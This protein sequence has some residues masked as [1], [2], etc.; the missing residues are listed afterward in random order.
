MENENLY[1]Q[2][3]VNKYRAAL[4]DLFRYISWFEQ[5][6]GQKSF[7]MYT[8]DNSPSQSVPIPVY[9]STLLSFVKEMQATGLMDRNY[10]Y[11][12]T[13]N[14]IGNMEDELAAIEHAGLKE[15]DVVMGILSKYV[16]GGMTKGVL[17][18]QAVDGGIFLH[19]LLKMKDLLDIWDKPLA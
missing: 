11:I 2:E 15:I 13:R 14:R 17:W 16:L 8:G 19:A 6:Q 5:K 9:D 3:M 18:T 4:G 7:Q 1:K 12:Y 10:Q